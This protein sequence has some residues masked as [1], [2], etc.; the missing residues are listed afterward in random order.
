MNNKVIKA[1]R[2]NSK[3]V[4]L[5]DK[6]AKKNKT[7]STQIVETALIEYFKSKNEDIF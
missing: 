1:Y 4:K 5:I 7:T 6:Y 2:L 3:V